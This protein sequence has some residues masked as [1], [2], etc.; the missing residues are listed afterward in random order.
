MKK[1]ALKT[2]LIIFDEHL[3]L[4][5]DLKTK[6]HKFGIENL[7]NNSTIPK[8][9]LECSHFFSCLRLF[10]MLFSQNKLAYF[11]CTYKENVYLL[12]CLR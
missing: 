4:F 8:T 6:Y 5:S 2:N 11:V 7:V 9:V 3:T 1:L 12:F 10:N